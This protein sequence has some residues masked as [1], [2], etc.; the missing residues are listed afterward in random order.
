MMYVFALLSIVVFYLGFRCSETIVNPL[1][2]FSGVWLAMGLLYQLRLS[3][4]QEALHE[5]LYLALI[6]VLLA[7]SVSWFVIDF[8]ISALIKHRSSGVI[9]NNA[10]VTSARI[11]HIAYI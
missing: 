1:S 8:G 7:F 2:A 3:G 11:E 9:K 5:E 6:I 10:I 4:L